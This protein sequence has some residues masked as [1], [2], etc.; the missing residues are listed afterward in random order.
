[1]AAHT[2]TIICDTGD[3]FAAHLD[4]GGVRI[5]MVG[6]V[7]HDVPAGHSSYDAIAAAND[8]TVESIFDSLIETGQIDIRLFGGIR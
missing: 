8:E 1:M 6:G 3:Y 5:G 4:N 2:T 7:C